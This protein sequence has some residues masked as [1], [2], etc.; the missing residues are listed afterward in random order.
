MEQESLIYKNILENM[1][2]G[3]MTI[4]FDGRIITFNPAAEKTLEISRHEI[5]DKNYGEVFFEYEEN[6]AFNQTI[7]DAI[8]EAS[9][10]HNQIVS[11]NTGRELKTL[12]L[13]T[14][15]L[16]TD[17]KD[18]GV[19]AVFSDITE[20][21]E[22]RDALKAMEKIK[23]LN[24]DLEVRNR[25][26]RE[27]FGRYLSDDVVNS[28]IE[29]PGGLKM[30]GETQTVTIMMTDLRGFTSLSERLQPQTVVEM[31]NNYLA[32]M[33]EILLKYKGTIDEFIG[34]AILA[35][36]GAPVYMED[37]A[38][39]AVACAVEMQIAMKEVNQ[40]NVSK[41][42]P[43]IEMGI[44]INTGN[45]VVG[46][47]GSKKRTKYGVVGSCVNLAGRIESFTTGGQILISE[48]TK[49]ETGDILS[50]ENQIEV[51]M[52]GVRHPVTIYEI[53]G[54]KGKHDLSINCS[55]DDY[56]KTINNVPVLFHFLD[57]KHVETECHEGTIIK[58]SRKSAI[59]HTSK[60]ID[61]YSN[62]KLSF[63]ECANDDKCGYI[64]A[65]AVKT[66]SDEEIIINI[67]SIDAEAIEFLGLE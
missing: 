64:Y 12:S 21:I 66:D 47:I 52:K 38:T 16:Q 43:E 44:G 33:T 25:F 32:T 8:Y 59:I 60:K 49:Q 31:L 53:N 46:N 1:K 4:D 67:L 55:D 48:R 29:R 45:V 6:D 28:L 42:F 3:V 14:T 5:I 23:K 62:I 7:F 18:I 41:G 40:W 13:T 10:N 15:Y 54:I 34:D 19:I 39:R 57:G 9:I 51:E 58:M 35:V 17:E 27:T 36:F 26:I 20:L 50:I 24:K 65:K 37:H 22:L 30:G 2:D 63:Q 56:C 11:F 61:L